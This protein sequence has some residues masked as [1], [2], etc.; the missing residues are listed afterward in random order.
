MFDEALVERK[1]R[2]IQNSAE[3]AKSIAS[4]EAGMNA[5]ERFKDITTYLDKALAELAELK[6]YLEEV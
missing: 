4:G 1:I 6:R 2:K 3:V 5:K